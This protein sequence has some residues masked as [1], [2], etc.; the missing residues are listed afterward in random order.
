MFQA[1]LLIALTLSVSGP[2]DSEKPTKAVPID[3]LQQQS[4]RSSEERQSPPDYGAPEFDVG[5]ETAT[6]EE[7]DPLSVE[8]RSLTS[9]RLTPQG[10]LLACDGEARLVKL[11]APD[12]SLISTLSLE[13]GP[14]A[15]DVASDGSIYCGG[16]GRLAHLEESGTILHT[17]DLPAD[18]ETEIVTRRRSHGRSVRVSGIAV[19]GEHVFAAFG[20]GGSLGS[21]SKLYRFDRD[22]KNPTIIAEGL[23]GCCQR[24]DLSASNG[25][26]YL[27]ENAAHRVVAYS[28]EG[29]VLQRWGE[30]SRA[31]LEGF[32]SC[33]N[34]MNLCF[35]SA[36][37][38]YTAES[39][40]GRVKRY[41][42]DGQY[43]GLV[44]YVGTTRFTRASSMANSC[45]NIAIDVTPDGKTVYVMDFKNKLIRVLRRK[46]QKTS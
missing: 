15:I 17:T 11:I 9:L 19:S 8:F 30:R 34:P 40:L 4:D 21:K 5:A 2:Q 35:D 23:R 36:G 27:A 29:E 26:L 16:E 1:A 43:L 12:G 13:F 38:L 44:G 31:E 25:T 28:S 6:H 10:N 18:A 37:V 20:S 39:G 24:C 32:G 41:S 42:T 33:C 3:V 14:E 7:V 45:S 46:D 22:L